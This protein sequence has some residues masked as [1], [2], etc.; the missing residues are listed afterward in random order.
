MSP[1]KAKLKPKGSKPK[2]AAQRHDDHPHDDPTLD[3][4]V[5]NWRPSVIPLMAPH[6][7]D[8]DIPDLEQLKKSDAIIRGERPLPTPSNPKTPG[9]RF[10]AFCGEVL[11]LLKHY[12]STLDAWRKAE[13]PIDKLTTLK[14]YR[15]VAKEFSK[16]IETTDLVE[17][18]EEQEFMLEVHTN[19]GFVTDVRI[20][21]HPKHKDVKRGNKEILYSHSRSY[22][23]VIDHPRRNSNG[24]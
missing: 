3:G 1:Q 24:K 12:N 8:E 11:E 16:L 13:S 23:K 7:H 9:E 6:G 15:I 4:I 10:T 18:S 20:F 19:A 21:A 2:P 22:L 17:T 5:P 14:A